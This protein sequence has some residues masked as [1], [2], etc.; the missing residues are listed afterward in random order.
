MTK[1]KLSLISHSKSTGGFTLMEVMIAIAIL[2]FIMVNVVSF[3]NDS[4]SQKERIKKQD[5][6]TM[7][8]ETVL[9]RIDWDISHLY[10]PLYFSNTLEQRITG[11]KGGST[12]DSEIQ[13][14]I[15]E[16]RREYYTQLKQRYESNSRFTSFSEDYLPIPEYKSEDKSSLVIFTSSNRRRIQ[17]SK[18]S[19]YSWIK[20]SLEKYT[21]EEAE[22][23][24][25]QVETTGQALVRQSISEDVF[26]PEAIDFSK[27]KSQILLK[28]VKK[29]TFEYW[30]KKNKKFQSRLRDIKN[31]K[32]LIRA[33]KMTVEWIDSSGIELKKERIYRP[34]FP[35]FEP[36]DI[37]ALELEQ[38]NSENS[39]DAD[40]E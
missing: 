17:N 33:V 37:R 2:S 15:D 3:S 19:V 21:D 22:E 1:R 20:Y 36:E 4:F 32:Y 40:E 26:N 7:H 31:G 12:N 29:L 35:Y 16:S 27:V 39:G 18:Q 13:T 28:N 9:E 38:V 34:L 24:D 14:S 5:R 11:L 8:I 10:S 25:T 6:E 23:S 30:D